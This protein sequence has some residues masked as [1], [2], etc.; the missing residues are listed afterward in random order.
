MLVCLLLLVFLGIY[1]DEKAECDS[2]ICFARIHLSLD[3]W[4]QNWLAVK[5][6]LGRHVN[7]TFSAS[8]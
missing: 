5:K 4:R 6:A 7:R 8:T 3:F 2:A 1:K